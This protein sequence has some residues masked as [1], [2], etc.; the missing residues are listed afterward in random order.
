MTSIRQ[1][2]ILAGGLGTRMRPQTFTTCKPMISINGKPFLAYLMEL[3]KKNGIEEVIILV[4]YLHK[5]IEEYFGA[6]EKFGLKIT[7]SYDPVEA[8][9]GTRVRNASR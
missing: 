1:A 3:L 6:G 2:V 4:G 7:Y 9:T 5:Q 8:D